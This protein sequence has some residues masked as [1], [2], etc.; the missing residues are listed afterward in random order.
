MDKHR[1]PTEEELQ[2]ANKYRKRC[3][4]SLA[5]EIKQMEIKMT[6]PFFTNPMQA[7]CR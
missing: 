7:Q 3:Q 6:R 4:T 5:R 2:R 1:Q